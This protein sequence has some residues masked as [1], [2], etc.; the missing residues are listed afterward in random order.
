MRRFENKVVLVT[1]AASGIGAATVE[2]LAEEG[3]TLACLD[4]QAD[5]VE[6]VAAA[7]RAA[8]VEARS[9]AVDIADEDAVNRV[10]GRGRRGLRAPRRALQHRRPHAHQPTATRSPPSSGTSSSA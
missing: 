9:W 8:G 6:E 5:A 3:A 10:V 4:V 2:R 1:G 7:A